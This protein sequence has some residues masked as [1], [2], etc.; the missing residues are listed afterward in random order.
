ML[1]NK[2][3]YL[4]ILICGFLLISCN[5]PEKSY[6]FDKQIKALNTS[7]TFLFEPNP[8]KWKSDSLYRLEKS[9][10]EKQLGLDFL[11]KGF[12]VIQIRVTYGCFLGNQRIIVLTN[13]ESRWSA[14]ISKLNEYVNPFFKEGN[15]GLS[16]E[17]LYRRKIVHKTPKSGWNSFI[18][19]L[20][21]LNILTLP[22]SEKLPDF[23]KNEPSVNDGCFVD[24]EVATKNAYRQYGYGNPDM[25]TEKYQEAK[26]VVSLASLLN[27]EF[28]IT[29]WPDNFRL[30]KGEELDTTRIQKIK[31]Q[32][33]ILKDIEQNQAPK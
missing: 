30:N 3:K 4:S 31:P 13:R 32:E 27:T 18:G 25:L 17:F 24:I 9:K 15:M 12:D 2:T 1:F 23:G 21:S 11:E 26:N 20:I 33:I 16:D 8:L 6:D 7:D 22:D 28:G 5:K 14:E 29:D 19:N 10:F